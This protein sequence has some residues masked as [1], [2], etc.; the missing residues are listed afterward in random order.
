MDDD[1]MNQVS[2][3]HVGPLRLLNLVKLSTAFDNCDPMRFG[4]SRRSDKARRIGDDF[5]DR[6]ITATSERYS[7]IVFAES[8]IEF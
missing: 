7:Y 4:D 2:S 8:F 6:S 3:L 5:D 1:V